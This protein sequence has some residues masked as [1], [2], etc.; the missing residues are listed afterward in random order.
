MTNDSTLAPLLVKKW[1]FKSEKNR[2][3]KF[4]NELSLVKTSDISQND[5]NWII[6]IWV[7]KQ[8]KSRKAPRREK[9]QSLVSPEPT[10]WETKWRT[11]DIQKCLNQKLAYFVKVNVIY[12]HQKRVSKTI[13]HKIIPKFEIIFYNIWLQCNVYV[14]ALDKPSRQGREVS[15]R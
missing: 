3:Y 13:L 5:G 14:C 12:N 10:H 11:A 4:K 2:F 1:S 6:H 9:C 7:T 8:A 15:E